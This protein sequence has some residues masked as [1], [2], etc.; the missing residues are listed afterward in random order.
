MNQ[1]SEIPSLKILDHTFLVVGD[2]ILDEND[3]IR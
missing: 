2:S 1:E 3:G